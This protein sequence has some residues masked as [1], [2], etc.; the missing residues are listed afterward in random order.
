MIG[1]GMRKSWIVGGLAVGAIV[2][3]VALLPEPPTPPGSVVE[4]PIVALPPAAS[5]AAGGVVAA[6]PPVEA[7]ASQAGVPQ[8]STPQVPT[9]QVPA[10][11]SAEPAPAPVAAA[12]LP[13]LPQR[14]I[15]ERPI[16]AVPEDAGQPPPRPLDLR[17]PSRSGKQAAAPPPQAGTSEAPLRRDPGTG[18]LF[19]PFADL[20]L[21]SA[22]APQHMPAPAARQGGSGTQ[23]AGT[24]EASG[25]TA[26]RIGNR[27][28]RLFGIS[29][30]ASGDR[31][32]AAGTAASGNGAQGR[33]T[34][35]CAEQAQGILAARLAQKANVSCRFP[36][37]ARGDGAAICLDGDGVDL[38]GMLVAEGLALADPAQS[39]DYVGAESVARSQKRGLWLFR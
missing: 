25:A 28:L 16:H 34:L 27:P 1:W 15:P 9:P 29:P 6:A 38:A 32:A 19:R 11:Q 14:V 22:G 7:A 30:P 35:P 13:E 12:A 21:P 31:C 37:A 33:R 10:A 17:D 36:G 3:A 24:A 39:Y 26:L 23:I 18:L 4:Q 20:Q 8:G 5:D 2:A